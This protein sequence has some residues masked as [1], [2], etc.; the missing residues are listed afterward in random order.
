MS[1][2]AE[3]AG[4][5]AAPS[6]PWPRRRAR[7]LAV[8]GGT[9]A[10][11][12]VWLVA[13]FAFDVELRGAQPGTSSVVDIGPQYVI[14]SAVAYSLVGWALLAILER[15]VA[16]ARTIWTWIA[17]AVLV[18][19]FASPLTAQSMTGGTKLALSIMH[20]AV[21]A[22]VIPIFARTSPRS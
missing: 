18:L 14:F 12:V 2:P 4:S 22:V 3:A 21:A 10:A 9:A 1:T 6:S 17:L 19:S 15:F 13:K 11:V 7:I 5:T 8:I 20:V 16:R